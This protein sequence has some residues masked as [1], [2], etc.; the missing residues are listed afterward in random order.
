MSDHRPVSAVPDDYAEFVLDL[1]SR[2]P[3]GR[4]STYGVLAEIARAETGRGSARTV[5]RVLSLYGGGV[6]WWRVCAA[7]GRLVVH[8]S[9]RQAEH[10]RAEGV[11]LSRAGRVPMGEVGWPD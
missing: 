8:K 2:I 6:P 5:G 9:E 4:V 10:L 3:A 11:V 1:V 7:G